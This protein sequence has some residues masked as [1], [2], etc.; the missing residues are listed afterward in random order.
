ME[1]GITL[2]LLVLGSLRE[3]LT[4]S[5]CPAKL[6]AKENEVLCDPTRSTMF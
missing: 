6:N 2:N 1:G 4:R 3:Y 5:R